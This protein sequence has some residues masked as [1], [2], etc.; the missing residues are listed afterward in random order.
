[1]NKKDFD[2][3]MESF[4]S[5]MKKEQLNNLSRMID[6]DN[7]EPFF[8]SQPCDCCGTTLGGN[9]IKA[10]GFNAETNEVEEYEICIDCEYFAEYGKLDDQT[11]MNLEE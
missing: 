7:D 2:D 10:S 9:R 4:D 11:M 8:S 3:F 6:D 1:M 5:F